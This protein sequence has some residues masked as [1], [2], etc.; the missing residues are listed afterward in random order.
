VSRLCVA[1]LVDVSALT[2]ALSRWARGLEKEET[3]KRERI[4]MAE[5]ESDSQ[6]GPR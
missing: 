3:G 1:H 6:G 5:N 4:E 2:L